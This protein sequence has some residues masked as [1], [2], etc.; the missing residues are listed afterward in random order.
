MIQGQKKTIYQRALENFGG[1]HQIRKTAEEAA[2]LIVVLLHHLDG[3]V[4]NEEVA[5]EIADVE[6]MCAQMR[7]IFG[8]DLVDRVK[9]EKIHRLGKRIQ[10][11]TD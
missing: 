1:T 6:I 2:E 8:Q 10:G 11:G 9:M 3:K 5:S 7:I 4:T